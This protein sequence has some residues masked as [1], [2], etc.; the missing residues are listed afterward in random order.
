[1]SM[2]LLGIISMGSII[3]DL[4]HSAD[5]EEK[6]RSI[7]GWVISYLQ[8]SRKPMTQLREKFFTISYLNLV[9]LRS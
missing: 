5:T 8:T 2:K 9:Y 1:M 7:M 4:L 6:N 3:T